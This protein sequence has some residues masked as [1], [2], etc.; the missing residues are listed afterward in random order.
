MEQIVISE[1][2]VEQEQKTKAQAALGEP[3][4]RP[5]LEENSEDETVERDSI[6]AELSFGSRGV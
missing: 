6:D 2:E 3:E 1:T 5:G 4:T